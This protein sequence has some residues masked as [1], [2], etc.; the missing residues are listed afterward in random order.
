MGARFAVVHNTLQNVGTRL[1]YLEPAIR[2]VV[3][4]VRAERKPE[5]R[6]SIGAEVCDIE[7]P[8]DTALYA[9]VAQQVRAARL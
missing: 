1:V 6:S 5:K 2:I 7:G 9:R 3:T 4:Q 8:E